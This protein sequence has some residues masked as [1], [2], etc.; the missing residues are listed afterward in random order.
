MEESIK[1]IDELREELGKIMDSQDKELRLQIS[2]E[3]DKAIL[4]YIRLKDID[5]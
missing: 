3:L 1:R 5:G 4:E 2:R